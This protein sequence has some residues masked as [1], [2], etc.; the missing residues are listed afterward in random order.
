[1]GQALVK[2]KRNP[3]KIFECIDG[4]KENIFKMKIEIQEKFDKGL[5]HFFDKDFPEATVV[6][7]QIIK[8]NSLD[9]AA[10]YFYNRAA[11]YAADGVPDGWTGIERWEVK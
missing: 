2:G 8:H 5:E 11:R 6:F 9:K 1:M 10:V 3:I 4:D 7:N